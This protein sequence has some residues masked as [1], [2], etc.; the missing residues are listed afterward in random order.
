MDQVTR[1]QL[2]TS[3]N[4]RILIIAGLSVVLLMILALGFSSLV[5]NWPSFTVTSF[6]WK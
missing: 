3:S 6:S 2:M 4:A 1:Y 5:W